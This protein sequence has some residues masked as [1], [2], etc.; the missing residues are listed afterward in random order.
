MQDEKIETT[1]NRFSK[2]SSIIRRLEVMLM[3][4]VENA[5]AILRLSE[6]LN[7]VTAIYDP[8]GTKDFDIT[9]LEMQEVIAKISQNIKL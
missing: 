7:T 9:G 8:E 6:D 5:L 1:E 2:L 3:L 4:D